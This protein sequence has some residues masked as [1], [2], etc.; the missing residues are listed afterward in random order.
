MLKVTYV[1]NPN[2]TSPW[3]VS[4]GLIG[5]VPYGYVA[6]RASAQQCQT[7]GRGICPGLDREGKHRN[8]NKKSFHKHRKHT[9][10]LTAKAYIK[11]LID[12]AGATLSLPFECSSI[13]RFPDPSPSVPVQ[14]PST[15]N[16]FLLI[17]L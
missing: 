16:S 13:T 3:L 1:V 8:K 10:E 7:S 9:Q 12:A 15:M 14:V 5:K 6:C 11:H 17:Y 4:E 2:K